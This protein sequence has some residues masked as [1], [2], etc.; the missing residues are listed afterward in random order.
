MSKLAHS[1]QPTM[2]KLEAADDQYEKMRQNGSL[3]SSAELRKLATSAADFELPI[4]A[5]ALTDAADE[6]R[7]LTDA[8]KAG[9][10][11]DEDGVMCIVSREACHAAAE[12]LAI[13]D[14]G[15]DLALSEVERLRTVE[16]AA[17]DFRQAVLWSG[18]LSNVPQDAYID[19]LRAL[20]IA[21]LI[22]NH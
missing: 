20:E 5:S 2:D 9:K 3:F 18:A 1:H 16:N 19:Q 21:L 10:Q 14:S 11:C 12:L 17:R 8:L 7:A 13:Q 15:L 22:A 6:I 4:F